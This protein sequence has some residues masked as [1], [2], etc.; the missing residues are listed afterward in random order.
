M[1]TNS[2][3]KHTTVLRD[4]KD[5][6]NYVLWFRVHCRPQLISL[7]MQNLN[8]IRTT[9]FLG[10]LEI[11][12]NITAVREMSGKVVGTTVNCVLFGTES[13]LSRRF[14]LYFATKK[15]LLVFSSHLKPFCSVIYSIL[16]ALTKI[17][18][19]KCVTQHWHKCHNELGLNAR[20]Q[21]QPGPLSV[22]WLLL[23]DD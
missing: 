17:Y 5:P 16:V 8:I 9:T 19:L 3:N 21:Q 12:G 1:T 20:E 14:E 15:I 7:H 11:S 23:P 4:H 13:V 2:P 6:L 22:K 18:R 10:N